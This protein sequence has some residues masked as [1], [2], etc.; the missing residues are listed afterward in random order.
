M[1]HPESEPPLSRIELLRL[2]QN[3]GVS[4][5]D[6][7]TRAELRA[8][9]DSARRP[10]P[11]SSETYPTTWVSVARRLLARVVERGLNLPD[12]A[13]LIRGDTKLSTPPKAP[14]PVATVTLARIYAAQGHLD[15]A[16][17]TLAEVLESDPDHELARELRAQ[18]ERRREELRASHTAPAASAA[19][20]PDVA[21]P[22][23]E[24]AVELPANDSDPI[25]AA[26]LAPVVELALTPTAGPSSS[27]PGELMA[28]AFDV[29]ERQPGART[30]EA[31]SI[32]Q[33][34][35][36]PPASGFYTEPPTMV[37]GHVPLESLP[38]ITPSTFP[39][40]EPP[41]TIA[42]GF[43]A[44]STLPPG[45]AL[46][47]PENDAAAGEASPLAASSPDTAPASAVPPPLVEGPVPEPP[48]LVE[49]PAAAHGVAHGVVANGA[50]ANGV[51][52][53][54]DPSMSGAREADVRAAAPVNGGPPSDDP[55]L[56][57]RPGL[58]LIETDSPIRYLYWEVAAAGLSSRF[59]IHVVA[60]VPGAA[61][62]ERR[63]RRFPVYRQRGALR[64]EGVP[65]RAVV[66]A[67]LT[68]DTDDTRSLVVAGAVRQ[69][70]AGG[71][72]QP[73]FAPFAAAHPEQIAQRASALLE[74]ASPVYWD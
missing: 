35:T 58:V 71:A 16:I 37:G 23:A 28:P 59:W 1:P 62:T 33:A 26:V 36:E 41:A 39:D 48:P 40:T 2:A 3:L 31:A 74:R 18:L 17:G 13:A 21:T 27:A 25:D 61:G 32:D 72:Y 34:G 4:D 73:S 12:A 44:S 64:L 10:E 14:P 67:R 60:H 45:P 55:P 52:L 66:R 53:G 30:S 69:P 11:E 65:A 5:A 38:P 57:A 54:T 46:T 56:P 49:P 51:S 8:A 50:V 15:R 47:R 7:M 6:V 42:V 24:E 70:P 43:E 22:E 19:S 20:E 9:I 68:A 29:I 63:E